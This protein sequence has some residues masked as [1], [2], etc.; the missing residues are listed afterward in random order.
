MGL[1][2]H[3]SDYVSHTIYI[4]I[5]RTGPDEDGPVVAH[6]LQHRIIEFDGARNEQRGVTRLRRHFRERGRRREPATLTGRR[7]GRSLR[8]ASEVL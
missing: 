6:G 1:T 3:R 2:N 4:W 5:G 8:L 7:D